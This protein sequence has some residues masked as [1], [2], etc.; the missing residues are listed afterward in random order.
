VPQRRGGGDFSLISMHKLRS[1]WLPVGVKP[2]L[3]ACLLPACFPC[4]GLTAPMYLHGSHVVD[5][6]DPTAGLYITS[7]SGEDIL[8][9]I[10]TDSIAFQVG[11]ALHIQSYRLLQAT[12]HFVRA[13]NATAA[14]AAA[15]KAK[16]TSA[17]TGSHDCSDVVHQ[18]LDEPRLGAGSSACGAGVSRN[19]FAVFMQPRLDTQL[20]GPL[21]GAASLQGSSCVD[22]TAGHSVCSSSQSGSITFGSLAQR[23]LFHRPRPLG[24]PPVKG[25]PS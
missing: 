23:E 10:P 7:R 22:D 20:G 19:T 9:D 2:C 17:R 1:Q 14:A 25:A 18:Q 21:L 6:P 12:P 15:A 24:P 4:P 16:A 8:V 13:P 11:R 3:L 5:S